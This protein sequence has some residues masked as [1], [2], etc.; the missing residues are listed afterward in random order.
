VL[1][2]G[3]HYNIKSFIL[4]CSY[5][6]YSSAHGDVHSIMQVTRATKIRRD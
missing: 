5:H 6:V 4:F 1:L 2:F 3:F